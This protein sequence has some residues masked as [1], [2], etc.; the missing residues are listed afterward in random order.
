[1][2]V[3]FTIIL[4][5]ILSLSC[6]RHN[7]SFVVPSDDDINKVIQTV[8][9]TNHFPPLKSWNKD[10]V[11]FAHDSFKLFVYR[12]EPI[13]I[14]LIKYLVIHNDSFGRVIFEKASDRA[15]IE[16][17]IIDYKRDSVG[18]RTIYISNLLE[19][20]YKEK[21]FNFKDT[22]YLF[23][24]NRNFGNSKIDKSRV[25]QYRF[26]SLD[27]IKYLKKGHYVTLSIPL[28]SS[29]LNRACVMIDYHGPFSD[30]SGIAI[31][32]KRQNGKWTIIGCKLAWIS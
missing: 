7:D 2:R 31:F 6:N 18:F 32:L 24:Q 4:I 20:D 11:V 23:F 14:G 29:D 30:G 12:K 9:Q 21:F 13:F 16:K 8:V 5:G 1:M 15:I 10:G 17:A 25:C 26:I 27:S 28:F 22:S 3:L 19:L